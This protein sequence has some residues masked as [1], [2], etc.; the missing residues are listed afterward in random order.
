MIFI[1]VLFHYFLAFFHTHQLTC[2]DTK[3]DII[4]WCELNMSDGT[5]KPPR[6][7][8]SIMYVFRISWIEFCWTSTLTKIKVVIFENIKAQLRHVLPT[9]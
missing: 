1:V 7:S 9:A 8:V 6:V 5:W 2:V 3:I 4:V